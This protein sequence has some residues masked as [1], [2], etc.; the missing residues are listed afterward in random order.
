MVEDAV[1]RQVSGSTAAGIPGDGKVEV[2]ADTWPL[3]SSTLAAGAAALT[4]QAASA[5]GHSVRSFP[6]CTH[7]RRMSNPSRF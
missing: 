3:I 2:C 7:P 5:A 4:V 1:L 6:L